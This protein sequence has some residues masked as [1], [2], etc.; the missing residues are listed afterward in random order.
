MNKVYCDN[1]I[2]YLKDAF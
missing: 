1:L 2:F